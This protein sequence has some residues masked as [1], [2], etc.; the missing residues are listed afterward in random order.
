[1]KSCGVH[2]MI[3][4]KAVRAAEW[5]SPDHYTAIVNQNH[6][7]FSVVFRVCFATTD[8]IECQKTFH[9]G[10]VR[11]PEQKRRPQAAFLITL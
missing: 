2:L 9:P 3:D 8:F 4:A 7:G 6:R 11:C 1:M 5:I 10:P